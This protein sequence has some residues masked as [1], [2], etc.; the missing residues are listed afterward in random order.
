[1]GRRLLT[2]LALAACAAQPA[3]AHPDLAQMQALLEQLAARVQALEA[4]NGEL[5]K[6]LESERLSEREPELAT[7]LKALE[8]RS[9]AMEAPVQR[10]RALDGIQVEGSLIGVGQSAGAGAT[11]SGQRETRLNYRGDVQVTLPAGEWGDVTGKALAHVRLGQGRGAGLR[12]TYTS[13]T[14]SLGFEV[15]GV[16]DPDSSFAILAQGWY[17]LDIPLS[18]GAGAQAQQRA[19]VTLGKID[20]FG[21]FD[22]N[23]IAADEATRFQNNV[24]VHNPLLDS[25]AGIGAD[26][27]GFAPGVILQYLDEG[28]KAGSWSY[29]LGVFGS[30]AGANFSG[31]PGKP[32]VIAQVETAQRL[33]HLPGQYRLYAWTNGRAPGWDG[34]AQRQHGVGLSVDQQVLDDLTL[35]ARWGRLTRGQTR[36]DSALTL[37][38]EWRGND[39]GRGG[40]AL[41]LAWGR[42]RTSKGF[43]GVSAT[44]DADGDGR[45]DW[46]YSASGAETL[47]ELY[48]RWNLGHGLQLTP[49]L[50]YIRRPGGDGAAGAV[51]VLGLRA[52]WAF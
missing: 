10:M 8:A 25:G 44:L 33:G 26:A 46:G 7:R 27:Y 31:S 22:G 37:G 28:D 39:W 21:F 40:D 19:R 50:Q 2:T 45:P 24:F 47:A 13:S 4:R 49:S 12:P 32:L 5:E 29:S 17:Q 38:G 23:Q 3:W 52:Q 51:R 9:Q 14:N 16:N 11:A 42:L 43:A 20:L 35:F 41:G 36:F 34:S 48:Y 15:G 1:M 18:G 6:A 30:G